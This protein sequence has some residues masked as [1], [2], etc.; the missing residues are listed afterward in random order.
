MT[1]GRNNK[2]KIPL[3]YRKTANK[4]KLRVYKVPNSTKKKTHI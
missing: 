3:S 2:T 1:H 4:D